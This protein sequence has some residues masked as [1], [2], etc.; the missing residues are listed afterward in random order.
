M[1]F[2]LFRTQQFEEDFAKLPKAE[3]EHVEKF[4]RKLIES[5]YLGKPL[6]YYFFREKRLNSRRVYF[7]I[8]EQY[9]VVLMV[10]TSDKKTQRSTIDSIKQK[11]AEYS[12]SVKEALGK[13]Q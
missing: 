12:K 4:E 7:L 13:A 10:A 11:L 2:K 8:Y 9:V 1:P 5:P 6:G 3:K